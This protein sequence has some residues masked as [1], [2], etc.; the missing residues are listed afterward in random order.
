MTNKIEYKY[1][2]DRLLDEIAAY[3]DSTYGQHYSHNKFQ[4]TEF[5]IDSGHGSG[6]CIG[7]IMKYAQRIGR[8]G[9]PEDWRKDI[10]KVIHYGIMQLHVHDLEH[11]KET[12]GTMEV[13]FDKRHK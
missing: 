7:N 8:K 3:V 13:V 4:T 12:K 11:P 9:G 1:S 5:I 6:F 10:L 2:E